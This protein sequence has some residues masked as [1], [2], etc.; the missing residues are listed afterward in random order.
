MHSDVTKR[1][2]LRLPFVTRV[3]EVAQKFRNWKKLINYTKI[4][5]FS[6][7]HGSSVD[8]KLPATEMRNTDYEV[9]RRRFL[10]GL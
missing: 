6:R 1:D 5:N 9:C 8:V 3:L 4:S 7:T 10:L 2:L